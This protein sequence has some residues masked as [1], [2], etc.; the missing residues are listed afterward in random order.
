[1]SQ[2]H[3]CDRTGVTG[4]R[5]WHFFLLDVGLSFNSKNKS[6]EMCEISL[7]ICRS[8][9]EPKAPHQHF[10]SHLIYWIQDYISCPWGTSPSAAWR[11]EMQ[12][13]CNMCQTATFNEAQWNA[14]LNCKHL[15]IFLPYGVHCAQL[16]CISKEY[17]TVISLVPLVNMVLHCFSKLPST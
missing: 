15:C 14:A 2:V 7:C 10:F 9:I 8:T 5:M 12:Q 16:N 6:E 4:A 13:K 17:Y 11:I 1:M 3:T